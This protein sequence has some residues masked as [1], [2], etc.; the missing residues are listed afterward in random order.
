ME[1]KSDVRPTAPARMESSAFVDP[2]LVYE[3]HF[4]Q[5]WIDE[6]RASGPVTHLTKKEMDAIRDWALREKK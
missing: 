4:D 2:R 3:T 6:A 5:K 1:K